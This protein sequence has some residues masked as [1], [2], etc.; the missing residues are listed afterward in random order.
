M[1]TTTQDVRIALLTMILKMLMIKGFTLS[2]VVSV[3]NDVVED[4]EA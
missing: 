1:S 3:W 2:E 4:K